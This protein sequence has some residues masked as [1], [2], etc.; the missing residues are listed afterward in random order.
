M[1]TGLVRRIRDP[2]TRLSYVL[3]VQPSAQLDH[4]CFSPGLGG[5][6]GA[7]ITNPVRA[8]VSSPVMAP[9]CPHQDGSFPSLP[10]SLRLP[11]LSEKGHLVTSTTW[12]ERETRDRGCGWKTPPAGIT[13][14]RTCCT[15]STDGNSTTPLS[16]PALMFGNLR[17]QEIPP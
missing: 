9:W 11:S 1:P 3:R 17:R 15:I 10:T 14:T 12:V 16:H 4:L 13:H 7:R 8:H 5:L 6:V 2:P